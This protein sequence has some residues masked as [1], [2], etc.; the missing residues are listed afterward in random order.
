MYNK[1]YIS[2]QNTSLLYMYMTVIYCLHICIH[3]HCKDCTCTLY[4]HSISTHVYVE[5]WMDLHGDKY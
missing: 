4:T 1:K 3:V 2:I 5:E